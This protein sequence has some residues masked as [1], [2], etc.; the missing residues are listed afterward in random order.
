MKR[1]MQ[2]SEGQ[3]GKSGTRNLSG[4]IRLA[5]F[6]GVE[7]ADQMPLSVLIDELKWKGVIKSALNYCY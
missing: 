5:T 1:R 6:V 2:L 3:V 4:V 7:R